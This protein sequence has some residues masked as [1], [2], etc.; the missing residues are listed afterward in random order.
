MAI[1]YCFLRKSELIWI[2]IFQNTHEENELLLMIN[3]RNKSEFYLHIEILPSILKRV[4]DLVFAKRKIEKCGRYRRHVLYSWT[5]QKERTKI[6]EGIEN[7]S[8]KNRYG[9]T[10]ETLDTTEWWLAMVSFMLVPLVTT[11]EMFSI[12]SIVLLSNFCPHLPTPNRRTENEL[13]IS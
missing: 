5:S 9:V 8:C 4:V 11:G 1:F 6:A 3:P 2:N 12:I 13:F 10:K 7:G